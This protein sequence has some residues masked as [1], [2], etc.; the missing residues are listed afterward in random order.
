[1]YKIKDYTHIHYYGKNGII[2]KS[3][4]ISEPELYFLRKFKYPKNKE[5]V[6]EDIHNDYPDFRL[7]ELKR[8]LNLFERKFKKLNILEYSNKNSKTILIESGKR[9]YFFPSSLTLEI[10]QK[11]PLNCIH[12]YNNCSLFGTDIEYNIIDKIIE[13]FSNKVY[14]ITISG[15][16]P[17][18][19]K[20]LNNIVK[21]LSNKFKLNLLTTGFLDISYNYKI[22]NFFDDIQISLYSYNEEKHDDFTKKNGSW[23][24]TM[25]FIKLL[26]DIGLIDKITISTII[27]P[28]NINELEDF[29]RTLIKLNIKKLSLGTLSKS[30]RATLLEKEYFFDWNDYYKIHKKLDNLKNKFKN[31]III[32]TVE[33]DKGNSTMFFEDFKLNC[34]AGTLDFVIGTDG[35]IKPCV[36]FP[37]NIFSEVNIL[38]LREED[39]KVPIFNKNLEKN[40]EIWRNTL[41]DKKI[42][43]DEICES[44]GYYYKKGDNNE[45]YIENTEETS[46]NK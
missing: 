12:C 27:T 11:C 3:L 46:Y 9:K 15:G 28:Q 24:K 18:L 41:K 36:F 10:S 31:K 43:P 29:I 26:N 5:N 42:N 21:K 32:N 13:L 38:E 2:N 44:V 22:L 6:L 34:F 25:N 7:I 40:M 4:I 39:F 17:F 20:N 33:I 1:M 37:G 35:Y 23:N 19:H 14:E 45:H 30:G 16:E 8:I